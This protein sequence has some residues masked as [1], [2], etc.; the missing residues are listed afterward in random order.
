MFTTLFFIVCQD[1][2]YHV[3]TLLYGVNALMLF[4]TDTGVLSQGLAISTLD[5]GRPRK[6]RSDGQAFFLVSH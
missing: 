1:V 5:S 4:F 2:Q 3:I 6:T